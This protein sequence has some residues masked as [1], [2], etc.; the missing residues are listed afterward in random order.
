MS[1][2]QECK[3]ARSQFIFHLA[4][5]EVRLEKSAIF[6]TS[7]KGSK[8][9]VR[10][11]VRQNWKLWQDQSLR[12]L[13][14]RALPRLSGYTLDLISR[15][16]RCVTSIKPYYTVQAL[17]EAFWLV[18]SV[19]NLLAITNCHGSLKVSRVDSMRASKQYV[20]SC[21]LR[22]LCGFFCLHFPTKQ[23]LLFQYKKR[24]MLAL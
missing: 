9:L 11:L 13:F 24:R 8:S 6:L 23:N 5:F 19:R 12:D 1:D 2:L 17:S 22:N 14:A 10:S 7:I 3:S 4:V 18:K 20:C 16:N 21:I 15:I